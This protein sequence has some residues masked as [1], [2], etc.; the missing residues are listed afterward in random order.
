[1]PTLHQ[2][3]PKTYREAVALQEELRYRVGLARLDRLVGEGNEPD[4]AAGSFIAFAKNP[5]H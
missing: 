1:M 3:G 2:I 5:S 4:L